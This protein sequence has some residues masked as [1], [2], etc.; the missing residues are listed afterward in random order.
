MLF[1]LRGLY[2]YRTNLA[3]AC[4]KEVYFVVALAKLVDHSLD[5]VGLFDA[6]KR[7]YNWYETK[8]V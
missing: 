5:K 3:L 1:G 6:V 7:I 4:D 2:F 8:N